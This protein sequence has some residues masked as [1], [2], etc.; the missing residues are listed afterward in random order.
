[1]SRTVKL[2]IGTES[3]LFIGESR[4]FSEWKL[5]GHYLT[6]FSVFCSAVDWR[7]ASPLFYAG[8]NSSHWGAAIFK[9]EDQ[10]ETWKESKQSP[11]FLSDG[12]SKKITS[13]VEEIWQL[14]LD[15]TQHPDSLYAGAAP[16]ALFRS[17]DKGE[18]WNEIKGLSKHETRDLW[19]PCKGGLCLHSILVDPGN[20]NHLT[21]GISAAGVFESFNRGETWKPANDGIPAAHETACVHKLVSAGGETQR[22]YQQ[23]HVGIWRKDGIE[24]PWVRIDQG[25]PSGYGFALAA[26]PHHSDQIYVI[27]HESPEMRTAPKGELA[28]YKTQDGGKSWS[29]S[30]QGLPF[31]AYVKVLREGLCIDEKNPH[32]LYFGTA[33]GSL[34][35]SRDEGDTWSQIFGYLPKIY[36]V[37][38]FSLS[39]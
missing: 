6:G 33:G 10:G 17:D 23:N 1:M 39:S 4:D 28:V 15:G 21:V 2:L 26:H 37:K 9:S 36:S 3:G 11:C 27:P 7:G 31:P 22:L 20:P 13:S 19:E 18:T 16:A 30:S 34:F 5:K 25:L 35:A 8:G 32:V 24:L 29:K 12:S 38:A 14:Q